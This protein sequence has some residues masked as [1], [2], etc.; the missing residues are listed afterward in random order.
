MAIAPVRSD[1][2]DSAA[3][4]VIGADRKDWAALLPWRGP[5]HF[6]FAQD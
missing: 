2:E 4:P 6:I 3:P 5:T 1:P